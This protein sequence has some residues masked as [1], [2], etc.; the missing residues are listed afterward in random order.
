MLLGSLVTL[1]YFGPEVN[2]DAPELCDNLDNDCD[3]V[4]DEDFD[5][6][7]TGLAML[8]FL[9]AGFSH[10]S[11]DIHDGIRFGDGPLGGA[12]TFFLVAL[13]LH[14]ILPVGDF[15]LDGKFVHLRSAYRL[16]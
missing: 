7:N 12:H 3:G 8:A 2:P 15:D 11:K 5:A 10:L 16:K 6:G 1:R 13:D 4:V 9:G 14:G